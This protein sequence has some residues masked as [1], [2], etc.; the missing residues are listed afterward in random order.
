MQRKNGT[1]PFARAIDWYLN[2]NNSAIHTG[3]VLAQAALE[4]L[5]YR[6]NQEEVK[7]AAKALKMALKETGIDDGIP[8]HCLHLKKVAKRKNWE[9]GPRAITEIRNDIVHAKNKFG[10]IRIEAQLD[11]W[12]L[13]LWYIELM[14]LRKIGYC[15]QYK[16]RLIVGSEDPFERVPWVREDDEAAK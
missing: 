7:P 12:H 1:T 10:C 3:I 13:S 4:S 6:I 15:G 11:A 8:S 14:L 2:S 5:S 16:N 9:H